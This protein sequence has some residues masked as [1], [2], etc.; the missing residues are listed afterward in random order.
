[1]LEKL[2]MDVCSANLE[3]VARGMVIYTWGNVSGVDREAGL[4]AIKPSGVDY[5]GMTP[6]DMVVVEL[7][8]GNVAEGK[9]KPSS[10][11]AS[12]LELYRAFPGLTGIVHTLLERLTPTA[13]TGRSH[14]PAA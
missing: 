11:T 14:A 13:F 12:H 9:W 6:E 8:S 1:M 5:A 10:D 3:L 2:K 7:A 4:M